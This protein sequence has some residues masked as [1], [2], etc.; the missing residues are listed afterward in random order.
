MLKLLIQKLTLKRRDEESEQV[1][2]IHTPNVKSIDELCEFLNIE[3]TQCAKS[4]VYIHNGNPV[5]VLML[6]NDEVNETKL[7]KSFRRKFQSLRIPKN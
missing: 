4:R 1:K 3:E 7:R 6:G 5:L 2:E